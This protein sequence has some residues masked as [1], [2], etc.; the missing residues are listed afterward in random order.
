MAHYNDRFNKPKREPKPRPVITEP[1]HAL[2]SAVEA[3]IEA[4]QQLNDHRQFG[5]VQSTDTLTVEAPGVRATMLVGKMA[6]AVNYQFGVPHDHQSYPVIRKFDTRYKESRY[7]AVYTGTIPWQHDAKFVHIPCFTRYVISTQGVVLNALDGTRIEPDSWGNYRLVCDG[8]SNTLRGY[9][10]STL[11]MLALAPLPTGFTDY[12]FAN[13]SHEL[14]F[15]EGALKWVPR[16]RVRVKKMSTGETSEYANILEYATC[17]IK[18][19]QVRNQVNRVKDYEIISKGSVM[20]DEYQIM[21]V[22]P[23][24]IYV[25]QVQAPAQVQVVTAPVANPMSQ[26]PEQAQVPVQQVAQ[27]PAQPVQAPVPAPVPEFD[28]SKA[29]GDTF[30][31]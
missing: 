5:D 31:F 11:K 6:M 29:F 30:Q 3:C 25:P 22:E 21:P 10:L 19:F 26:Y 15:V 7:A 24:E 4:R 13:Y 27:A 8:F 9:P 16:V 28:Q 12:G 14:D 18:D 17:E 2:D 20:V 23:Q 1:G